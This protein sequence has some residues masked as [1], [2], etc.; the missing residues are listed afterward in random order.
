MRREGRENGA[1][2]DHNRF[3]EMEICLAAG[4]KAE[5]AETT[6]V[7]L[8]LKCKGQMG[9]RNAVQIAQS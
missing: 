5:K 1:D 2:I 8:G 3:V 4:R 9:H 6:S 7:V